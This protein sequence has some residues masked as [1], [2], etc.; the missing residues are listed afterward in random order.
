M[1]D[2]LLDA[3][4]FP[5]RSRLTM[6]RWMLAC[7]LHRHLQDPRLVY[8]TGKQ[9]SLHFA[10]PQPYQ[11]DGDVPADRSPVSQIQL[12]LQPGVL[13]VLDPSR[14]PAGG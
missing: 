3:V 14:E 1:T 11:L 4:F 12:T 6:L 7:R 13:P 5:C 8:R 9:V 2:G 10:T